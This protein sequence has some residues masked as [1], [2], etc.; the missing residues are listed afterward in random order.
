LFK[1]EIL[2]ASGIVLNCRTQRVRIGKK[3]LSLS[4]KEFALLELLMRNKGEVV[5]KSVILE[6][7]WDMKANPFSNSLEAHIFTL[8]EKLGRRGRFII[9][10][11]QGRGYFIED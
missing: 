5:S 2:T 9:Q 6:H 7:V 4:K 3:P 11:V 10:N 1:A 8:R